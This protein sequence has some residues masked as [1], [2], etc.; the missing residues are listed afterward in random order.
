MH[1]R[2]KD[3]K[4]E[5]IYPDGT[6]ETIFSVPHYSFNWQQLYTLKNPKFVPKGTVIRTTAH[7]DNS[8]NNPLNPDPTEAVRWGQPS[9]TEMMG[10]WVDYID[11]VKR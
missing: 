10:F 7:F 11:V 6:S 8:P 2:G 5:A 4:T 1:F 3:M 9:R